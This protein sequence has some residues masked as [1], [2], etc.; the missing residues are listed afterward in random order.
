MSRRPSS[1]GPGL[2][3]LARLRR[4]GL[5]GTRRSLA[6]AGRAL[7]AAEAAAAEIWA[8]PALAGHGTGVGEAMTEGGQL[9]LRGCL[10]EAG[11]RHGQALAVEIGRLRELRQELEDQAARDLLGCRQVELVLEEQRH[12]AR[13]GYLARQQRSAEELAALKTARAP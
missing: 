4:I 10:L 11:R 1:G 7:A 5:D 13:A 6:E 3:V 12:T 2:E 8:S 9:A